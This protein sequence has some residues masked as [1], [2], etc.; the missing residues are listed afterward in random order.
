MKKNQKKFFLKTGKIILNDLLKYDYDIL[1]S[2][3]CFG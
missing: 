3:Y 1:A 2:I